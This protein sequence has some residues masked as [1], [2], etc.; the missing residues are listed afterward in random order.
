MS[1]ICLIVARSEN[2]VIGRDNQLPWHLP[3]D[4]K[5]FKAQ[6]TGFPVIMGRKTWLSLGRALP[7]R[8]NIVISSLASPLDLP[9]GVI[10]TSSL[11]AAIVHA[12]VGDP[13][14]IFII[15][16]A[17]LFSTTLSI[18]DQLYLTVI[19]GEVAGD[20]IMPLDLDNWVLM[21]SVQGVLDDKNTIPHRFE[22]WHHKRHEAF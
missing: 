6:T 8:L 16:G 14:R 19:E 18:A 12:Q 15:G 22:I 4:L 11:D 17:Q 9:E 2:G 7:N 20:V 10:W 13:E 21:S 1:K 3:A 5:Y